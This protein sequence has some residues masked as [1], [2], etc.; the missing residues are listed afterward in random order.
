M[1]RSGKAQVLLVTSIMVVTKTTPKISSEKWD[2]LD[3]AFNDLA[4]PLHWMISN[5]EIPTDEAAEQLGMILSNLLEKE[6]DFQESEN[7]ASGE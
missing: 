2:L 6:P 7:K 1:R 4:G 5:G 3:C